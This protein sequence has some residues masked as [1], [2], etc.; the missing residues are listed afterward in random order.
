MLIYFSAVKQIFVKYFMGS[1]EKIVF[2]QGLSPM[3]HLGEYKSQYRLIHIRALMCI[4]T[5]L[6]E[7]HNLA[8]YENIPFAK[9]FK[10]FKIGY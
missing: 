4:T 3:R 8:A 1:S 2:F 5:L 9:Y 10:Q 6:L 7:F